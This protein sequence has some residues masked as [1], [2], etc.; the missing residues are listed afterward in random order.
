MNNKIVSN[1][2]PI[3]L[4]FLFLAYT[5]PMID[6]SNSPPGRFLAILLI[7]YYTILDPIFGVLMCILVVLFYQSDY[8]ELCHQMKTEKETFVDHIIDPVMDADIRANR[9]AVHTD[10]LK[11]DFQEKHCK[12]G[13][14]EYKGMRVR[15]EMAEH[16]FPELHFSKAPCNACNNICDYYVSEEDIVDDTIRDNKLYYENVMVFP[17]SSKE[18]F[19]NVSGAISNMNVPSPALER[20]VAEPFGEF[21]TENKM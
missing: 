8:V 15:D 18:W 12:A 13:N 4:L 21:I 1:F 5:Q 7:I 17:K 10:P 19:S 11:K 3:L 20:I 16:V 9:L 6:F 14:L 2:I